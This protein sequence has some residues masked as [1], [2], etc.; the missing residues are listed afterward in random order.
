[1]S[2]IIKTHL[3]LSKNGNYK[4]IINQSEYSFPKTKLRSNMIFANHVNMSKVNYKNI[5]P[6]IQIKEE[7]KEFV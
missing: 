4:M 1:M 2:N 3:D 7:L 6:N 5:N